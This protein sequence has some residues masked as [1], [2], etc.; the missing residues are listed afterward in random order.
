MKIKSEELYHLTQKNGGKFEVDSLDESYN[1]CKRI[2]T[3][4]YENFPVGSF[5]IPKKFRKYFYPVYAFSRIADDIADE[6]PLNQKDYKLRLLND[7]KTL[8]DAD[9]INGNP[10]FIALNDIMAKKEI[11]AEPLKKL[12]IAFEMD[13]E[14]KQA[15]NFDDIEEYCKYSANP[16][17]ELVLRIF[18]LYNEETAPLSDSIC[19]GLQ[20]ANFWQDISEDMKK[21]RIY[22]PKEVLRKYELSNKELIE[23]K[24]TNLDNCLKEI[25]DYTDNFFILGNGI[26][27]KLKYFRLKL[28]ISAVIEGGKAIMKKTREMGTDII[29]NRPKL[30]KSDFILTLFRAL[31]K[32]L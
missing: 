32:I 24:N 15:E 9:S 8:I 21:G 16:V 25:Y 23:I 20:L 4:H 5:L 3:G 31:H 17:G 26:I 27:D 2:A 22:I 13:S 1:F 29:L 28:E 19:T 10:I 18:N 6:L 14:F 11:P 7:Y 30:E 12:I